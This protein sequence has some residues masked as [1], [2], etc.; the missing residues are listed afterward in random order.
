M[1]NI[2]NILATNGW[3]VAIATAL[4]IL[5]VGAL[6]TFHVFDKI[7]QKARKP[8]YQAL[9]LAFAAIFAVAMNAIL[10]RPWN[11]QFAGFA[12][13]VAASVNMVY[14]L[15]EN[16]GLRDIVKKLGAIII[17]AAAGE[18][19]KAIVN[20][21]LLQDESILITKAPQQLSI[22]EMNAADEKLNAELSEEDDAVATTEVPKPPTNEDKLQNMLSQTRTMLEKIKEGK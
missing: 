14:P 1:T 8:L 9:N 10:N 19:I 13:T 15:Y 22:A 3:A 20:T 11:Q 12:I 18:R 5:A 7:A 21:T 2:N 17:N 4:T 16:L 6:K